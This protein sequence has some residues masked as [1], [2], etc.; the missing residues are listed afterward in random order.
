MLTLRKFIE[1]IKSE[2]KFSGD[3]AYDEPMSGHTTFKLGGKADVWIRPTKDI[4]PGFASKLLSCAKKEGI[5]VF[6]LGAGANIL[7]SDRGIRGIVL[8]TGYWSGIAEEEG[9]R[10]DAKTPREEKMH[11]SAPLRLCVRNSEE[12]LFVKVLSGTPADLLADTLAG[13]GL[14]GVEFLASLPA[15]VGGAVLMNARCYGKSVSDVLVNTEIL[16]ENQETQ[17]IPFKNEDFAY[18]KSPFQNRDILILSA[19]FAVQRGDPQAI[20][21]EMAEYR[22]D[23]EEKGHFRYPSAGSAFKNNPAF[24]AP[25]GKIIADL[26]L[27][28]LSIG[29]AQIAPW[30]GNII[31]NTGNASANDVKMLMAETAKRVKEERGFDLENEVIFIGDWET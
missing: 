22:Q 20:S 28:S 19:V 16:D 18:K 8:D 7:V 6:V 11:I 10:R 25:T 13:E 23:R 5:P 9:S 21:K 14:S 30:H 24:G 15:S 29:G 27:R 31:I 4:F 3:L 12:I 26:G 17:T 1:K 2:A